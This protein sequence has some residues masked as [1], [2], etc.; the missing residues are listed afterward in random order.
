MKNKMGKKNGYTLIELLAVIVV[1]ALLSTVAFVSI[2]KVMG[3][4]KERYYISLENNLEAVA[5][6]FASDN[7]N[8][9][10]KSIG[11]VKK[12]YLGTLKKANYIKDVI[13]YNKSDC[14]DDQTYVQVFKYAKGKY[15]YTTFLV[16]PTYSTSKDS[17]SIVYPMISELYFDNDVNPSNFNFK[18]D[19][20]SVKL[21]S[22]TVRIYL[23][24]RLDSSD[25]YMID[26]NESYSSKFSL[27]KYRG[28]TGSLKIELTAI[29]INGLA[30]TK[31][32]GNV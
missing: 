11:G 26:G 13:D 1:L 32:I 2:S 25:T 4:A 27:S 16:C 7:R 30:T 23:D 15:S 29:N 6:D 3:T 17:N 18:I 14:F 19:G 9:L 12:I 22:Y 20:G 28:N 10:P 24:G 8:Y 21:L 5:R 31:T